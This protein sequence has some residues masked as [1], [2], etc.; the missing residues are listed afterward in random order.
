MGIREAYGRGGTVVELAGP[1]QQVKKTCCYTTSMLIVYQKIANPICCKQ[2]RVFFDCGN[3][4]TM[5]ALY[6]IV[7]L[8]LS[9]FVH[10]WT[11][12]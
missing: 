10:I 7:A 8:Y 11:G 4:C 12:R 2:I 9:I 5:R 6:C 1:V 3:L